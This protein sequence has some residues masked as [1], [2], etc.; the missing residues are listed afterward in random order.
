[1]G[2]KAWVMGVALL[3]GACGGSE[4]DD[5]VVLE[6]TEAP[7]TTEQSTTTEPPTTTSTTEP[8]IEDPTDVVGSAIAVALDGLIDAGFEVEQQEVIN[9]EADD[10][11]VLEAAEQPDGT[12]LL[13]VARPP[14][15]RFL[16]RLR[17]VEGSDTQNLS[18]PNFNVSGTT[19][20]HGVA[21]STCGADSFTV[22]YDLGR[23]FRRFLAT[24]GIV[25]TAASDLRARLELSVDGAIVLTHDFV[26][27]QTVPVDVDLTGALRIRL[28]VAYLSGEG[29]RGN[30]IGLGDA[31]FAGVPSEVPPESAN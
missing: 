8:Q 13:T 22:E 18:M 7:E 3:L 1:M 20:T 27:G 28:T 4:G 29:C 10:G 12:V 15:E 24:A 2:R 16:E 11:E 19:Y 25:D 30:G 23:D 14:V 6:E 21:I 17:T 5:G 26:L 9:T 31:R